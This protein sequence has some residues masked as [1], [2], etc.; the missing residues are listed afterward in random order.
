MMKDHEV[1]NNLELKIVIGI[2]IRLYFG[3]EIKNNE[4]TVKT[5]L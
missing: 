2:L 1:S 4:L 3:K 5:L